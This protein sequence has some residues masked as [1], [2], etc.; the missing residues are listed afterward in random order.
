MRNFFWILPFLFFSLGYIISAR[1]MRVP[2]L[3]VPCITHLSVSEGLKRASACGLGM[4]I[5]AE[6]EESTQEP[7]IIIQQHPLAGSTIKS[8]QSLY[9]VVS[10]E[11]AHLKIPHLQGLFEQQITDFGKKNHAPIKYYGLEGVYPIGVCLAHYPRTDDSLI[12]QLVVYLSAGQT[13]MRILPSFEGKSSAQVKLFLEEYGIQ[14]H[15]IGEGVE[16]IQLSD[17]DIII[18]Q[19]PLAGSLIDIRKPLMIYIR[20]KSL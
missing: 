15:M 12:D 3:I 7:G 16:N 11:Q 18:D 4:R 14:L 10:K 17:K 9:V 1:F 13:S 19:K 6:Q 2:H 5:I 20:V 8:Q